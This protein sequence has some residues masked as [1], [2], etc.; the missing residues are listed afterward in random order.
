MGINLV[1]LFTGSNSTAP[2]HTV[3]YGSGIA[4]A[5]GVNQAFKTSAY[6]S[7]PYER[8]PQVVDT[9]PTRD[10]AG[11][12]LLAGYVTPQKVWVA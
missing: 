2:L 10:A 3:E 5:R 9:V 6:A 12:P 7:V 4:R 11:N 8:A 1:K